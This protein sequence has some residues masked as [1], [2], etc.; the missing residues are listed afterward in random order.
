ME[1]LAM[2]EETVIYKGLV[3]S[4]QLALL[5][6]QP[7]FNITRSIQRFG[8]SEKALDKEYSAKIFRYN[9]ND[10]LVYVSKISNF[11]MIARRSKRGDYL[12]FL[13]HA[14]KLEYRAL[15]IQALYA[16]DISVVYRKNPFRIYVPKGNIMLDFSGNTE[17]LK[18]RASIGDDLELKSLV[19]F[20]LEYIDYT[21]SLFDNLIFILAY[22][23][24]DDSYLLKSHKFALTEHI[25]IQ[26]LAEVL[27]IKY[28]KIFADIHGCYNLKKEN[29]TNGYSTKKGYLYS[30]ITRNTIPLERDIAIHPFVGKTACIK[31]LDGTN[32]CIYV[33]VSGRSYK[34]S[35]YASMMY[36]QTYTKQQCINAAEAD[37][38]LHKLL[39]EWE[40]IHEANK[41]AITKAFS[42]I[43]LNNK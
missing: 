40:A 17:S 38:L 28:D 39:V 36:I 27:D 35:M 30:S 23:L 13:E 7:I 21:K 18:T 26:R 24:E 9:I 1:Y 6:D 37:L 29:R 14:I 3:T 20:E 5:T 4:R 15:T 41:A 31:K 19:S 2:S 33:P 8:K 22:V 12:P 10:Q 16:L 42:N 43:T 11:L 25:T 32:E 34:L